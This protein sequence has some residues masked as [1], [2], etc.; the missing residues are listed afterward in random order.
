MLVELGTEPD[1]G[2]DSL[3]IRPRQA[4]HTD[5]DRFDL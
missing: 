1:V 3:M 5:R 4:N 2:D